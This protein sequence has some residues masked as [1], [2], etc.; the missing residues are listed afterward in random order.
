MERDAI[1]DEYEWGLKRDAME[2]CR[3]PEPDELPD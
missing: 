2:R 3:E 1:A